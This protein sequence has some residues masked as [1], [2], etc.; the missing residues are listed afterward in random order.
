MQQ[1]TADM[2]MTAA[3]PSLMVEEFPAVT[4]PLPSR[5]N[6]GLSLLK[7]SKVVSGRGCS[8]LE[9]KVVVPLRP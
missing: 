3:A 7:P 5:I 4:D 2:S 6:A 9:T 1:L 8:S